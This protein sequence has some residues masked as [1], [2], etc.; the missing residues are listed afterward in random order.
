MDG[1]IIVTLIIC[2][3]VNV[4]HKRNQKAELIKEALKQGKNV[5]LYL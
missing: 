1:I 4:I 2:V 3:T 5:K